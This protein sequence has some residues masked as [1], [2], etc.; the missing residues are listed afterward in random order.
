MKKRFLIFVALILAAVSAQAFDWNEPEDARKVVSEW[1]ENAVATPEHAEHLSCWVE[2]EYQLYDLSLGI[3]LPAFQIPFENI[4]EYSDETAFDSMHQI[5][6]WVYIVMAEEKPRF[7]IAVREEEGEWR[8]SGASSGIH[9]IDKALKRW[10]VE[11]GYKFYLVA[12]SGVNLS[13]LGVITPECEYKLMPKF[14][15]ADKYFGYLHD[16]DGLYPLL[17]YEHVFESVLDQ[18]PNLISSMRKEIKSD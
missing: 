7:S 12:L 18:H 15:Y 8:W 10:P 1:L 9:N 3:A 4:M 16:D 17:S 6:G 13:F 2:E 11:S 5:N 14:I